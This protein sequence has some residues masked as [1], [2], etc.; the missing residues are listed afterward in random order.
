MSGGC[1]CGDVR[2]R[3]RTAPIVTNCCHCRD[4]QTITGSAFAVNA[5]IETDRIELTRGEVVMRG[6]ERGGQGD[7]H[8]WRCARCDTLLWADHPMFADRVRFVRVGT[9]DESE[10]LP[11]DAHYFTRSK[12]SWIAIPTGVAQFETLPEDGIGVD[13]GGDRLIRLNALLD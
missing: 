1:E 4:C 2:Y 9:L 10:M 3:L 7:T 13:L 11:P 6:L 5:M 8:A 12:H